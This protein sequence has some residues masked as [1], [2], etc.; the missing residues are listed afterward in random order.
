LFPSLE[1]PRI[2]ANLEREHVS[3]HLERFARLS[4]EVLAV[5]MMGSAGPSICALTS[6]FAPATSST[7]D[8]MS[9]ADNRILVLSCNE[10]P[11]RLSGATLTAPHIKLF[12]AKDR[13]RI[14]LQRLPRGHECR[15]SGNAEQEQ[16]R[17]EKGGRIQWAHAEQYALEQA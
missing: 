9:R 5:M 12:I 6:A 17:A 7:P 8:T 3:R 16:R 4:H 14:D 1:S 11:S 15:G 2:H 13:H 10:Q